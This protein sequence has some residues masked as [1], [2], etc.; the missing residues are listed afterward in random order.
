MYVPSAKN[1]SHHFSHHFKEY[2]SWVNLFDF[3]FR[4]VHIMFNTCWQLLKPRTD[5]NMWLWWLGLNTYF[6]GNTRKP[7]IKL[8]AMKSVNLRSWRYECQY[9]VF[10]FPS[11]F[12]SFKSCDDAD[13]RVFK[14]K[15]YAIKLRCIKFNRNKRVEM[16]ANEWKNQL[17]S[18]ALAF[19][20][21]RGEKLLLYSL[22]TITPPR[23]KK[24]LYYEWHEMKKL[25]QSYE[26]KL[27]KPKPW[28]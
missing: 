22:L 1:V 26:I 21:F 2:T 24:K 9:N 12:T 5:Y 7:S 6:L 20:R 16:K 3:D 17:N 19:T 15:Y 4:I 25:T 28:Q 27:N 8:N 23:K 18:I 11:D 13:G 14:L 10:L